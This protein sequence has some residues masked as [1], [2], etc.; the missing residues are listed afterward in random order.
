MVNQRE[1]LWE[2]HASIGHFWSAWRGFLPK[3]DAASMV[4]W[5]QLFWVYFVFEGELEVPGRLA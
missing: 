3:E 4:R 5:P 1:S 2:Q